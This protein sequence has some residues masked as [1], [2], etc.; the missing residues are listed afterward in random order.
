M[1]PHE[2]RSVRI[3]DLFAEFELKDQGIEVPRE[4]TSPLNVA[5]WMIVVSFAGIRSARREASRDNR[6]F[7]GR[8][9][10]GGLNRTTNNGHD[11]NLKEGAWTDGCSLA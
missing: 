11:N 8:G 9:A 4:N 10:S 7:V 2:A 3:G 6:M 5:T 1:P